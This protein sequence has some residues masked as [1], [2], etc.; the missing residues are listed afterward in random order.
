MWGEGGDKGTRGPREKSKVKGQKS[1]I[2]EKLFAIADRNWEHF[3]FVRCRLTP[4]GA[5]PASQAAGAA[6]QNL[7]RSGLTATKVNCSRSLASL[8]AFDF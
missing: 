5:S 2:E 6:T 4:I 7:A 8:L 3:S 1:C